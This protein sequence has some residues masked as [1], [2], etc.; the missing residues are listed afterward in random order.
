MTGNE[1][2]N[3]SMR[4]RVADIDKQLKAVVKTLEIQYC[5]RNE[6]GVFKCTTSLQE[7]G[8]QFAIIVKN[9]E[10]QGRKSDDDMELWLADNL[11]EG[12][13]TRQQ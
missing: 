13:Q 8:D 9:V 4:K 2:D 11:R 7:L 12:P 5:D 1:P 6:K 3:T 10:E